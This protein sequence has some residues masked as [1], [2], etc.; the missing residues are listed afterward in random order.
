LQQRACGRTFEPANRIAR[1]A[2]RPEQA[3]RKRRD[4][5]KRYSAA[6]VRLRTLYVMPQSDWYSDT[7]PRAL[8]VLLVPAPHDCV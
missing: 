4:V 7:D 8:E 5:Q 1:L 3:N 2:L 6:M